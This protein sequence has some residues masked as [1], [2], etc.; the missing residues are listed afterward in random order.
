MARKRD[1]NNQRQVSI[2]LCQSMIHMVAVERPSPD[3]PAEIRTKSVR[4][5]VESSHL[6]SEAGLEGLTEALKTFAAEEKLTGDTVRFAISG[7]FCVTRVLTG[8]NERVRREMR[9]LEDRCQRYLWLGPGEKAIAGSVRA[10]DARHQHALLTVANHK[11]L[12]ALIRGAASVGIEIDRVE[13][14]IVALCRVMGRLGYDESQ[15]VIVADI[16]EKGVEL[17]ISYQGQLLLDYRPGGRSVH[18]ELGD[19]I[20]LHLA[21]LQ[22]YCARFFRFAEGELSQIYLCGP[23][24]LVEKSRASFAGHDG[25][26]VGVPDLEAIEPGGKF[27]GGSPAGDLAPALGTSLIQS[28]EEN[29]SNGPNLMDGAQGRKTV[30]AARQILQL[31]SPIA[32]VLLIAAGMFLAVQRERWTCQAM[33]NRLEAFEPIRVKAQTL[34]MIRDHIE[35]KQKYMGMISHRV[36]N[37]AWHDLL[38]TVGGCLPEDVWLEHFQIGEEGKIHISGASYAEDAV[39]EFVGW[40][41]KAPHFRQVA[42]EGTGTGRTR[43][44]GATGFQVECQLAEFNDSAEEASHGK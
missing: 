30:P 43:A 9:L 34:R 3:L 10:V 31:I 37:P 4:W 22:R 13:P 26:Q 36:A 29:A 44:V 33:E 25:I 38:G 23:E 12:G 35:A 16:D 28:T 24:E 7:D 1:N 14:S 32:A 15:P 27:P 2:E 11:T 21:R 19:I 39:F 8:T 40:L 17:G 41:E 6:H 18:T 5:R 42:L 20:S